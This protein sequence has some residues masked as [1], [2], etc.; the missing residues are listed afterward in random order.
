MQ[1]VYRICIAVFC[2]TI[3]CCVAV[4]MFDLYDPNQ[5]SLVALSSVCMD[6]VCIIILFILIS[7]FAFG[8]SGTE[9][10][11]RWYACLL[12]GTVWALFLDFLNWA[13]D[14]AL[15]LG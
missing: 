1:A 14:G 15:E 11:T 8:S 9:R 13:F 2:I 6:M 3:G 12:V 5:N 4:V 7:S 10:T